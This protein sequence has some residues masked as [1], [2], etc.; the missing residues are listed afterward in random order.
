[1]VKMRSKYGKTLDIKIVHEKISLNG[2][3]DL[4]K[5]KKVKM[6][7]SFTLTLMDLLYTLQKIKRVKERDFLNRMF[8]VRMDVPLNLSLRVQNF[9]LRMEKVS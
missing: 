9:T 4:L 6:V 5:R 2:L 1:M 8:V 7:K 3:Q